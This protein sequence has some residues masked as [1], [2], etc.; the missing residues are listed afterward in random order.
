MGGPEN[1]EEAGVAAE[2]GK[3]CPPQ[4]PGGENSFGQ[5]INWR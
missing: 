5:H 2:L 1:R 4:L 3:R